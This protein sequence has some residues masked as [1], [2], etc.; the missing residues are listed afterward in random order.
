[1]FS[2]ILIFKVHTVLWPEGPKPVCIQGYGQLSFWVD[3]FFSPRSKCRTGNL[4]LSFSLSLFFLLFLFTVWHVEF[5]D[6]GSDLGH[7]CYLH[8]S[9][10]NTGSFHSAG[11][12]IKF[13]FWSCRD[14]TNPI[15]TQWELQDGKYLNAPLKVWSFENLG[16]RSPPTSPPYWLPDHRSTVG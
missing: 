16:F 9:Y 3:I 12:R 6:Q 13:A 15:V 5:P 8:H 4:S 1:M 11:L 10:G 2:F 7:I 14:V